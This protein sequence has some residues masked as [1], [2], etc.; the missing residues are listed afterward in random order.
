[1]KFSLPIYW[2]ILVLLIIGCQTKDRIPSANM[3]TKQ[4]SKIVIYQMMV[5]LFGNTETLNKPYGTLAENGTGKFND[6][7]DVALTS[8]KKLGVSH[9][10]YTGALEHATLSAYP[11]NGITADHPFVVKG[12]AGSPYSIKDYYD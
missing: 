6:V 11:A 9:V 10:W 5:R 4:P 12:R 2:I 3:T 1:M 7:N 8:L